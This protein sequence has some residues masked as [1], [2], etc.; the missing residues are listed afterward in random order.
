[1]CMESVRQSE[2]SVYETFQLWVRTLLLLKPHCNY[3][4]SHTTDK[5]CGNFLN[6]QK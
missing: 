2:F 1:M 3:D 5:F 6:C 4:F